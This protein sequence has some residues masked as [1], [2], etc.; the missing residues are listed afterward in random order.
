[1]HLKN[2]VLFMNKNIRFL[3]E[4]YILTLLCFYGFERPYKFNL[5]LHFADN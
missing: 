4:T 1:M 2:M 5:I 3:Y